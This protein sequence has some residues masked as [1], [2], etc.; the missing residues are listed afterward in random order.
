MHKLG[1]S[2]FAA[3]KMLP[4]RYCPLEIELSLTNVATDW[5]TGGAGNSTTFSLENVQL[6]Y[7][8]VVPDEAVLDSFYEALM[9]SRV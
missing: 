5:L 3:G 9:A 4:V 6:L 8:E 1:L 7:D 2:I